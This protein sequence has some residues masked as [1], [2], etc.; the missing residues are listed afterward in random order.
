[1]PIDPDELE[2][3]QDIV[4]SLESCLGRMQELNIR[5][6]VFQEI[7]TRCCE[8]T[9]RLDELVAQYSAEDRSGQC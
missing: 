2:E 8:V 5:H 1:M 7:F 3:L 6:P 9:D 4:E